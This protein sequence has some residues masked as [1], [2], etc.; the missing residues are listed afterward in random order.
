MHTEF[1]CVW[2]RGKSVGKRHL[3][4]PKRILQNNIKLDLKEEDM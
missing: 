1:L 2:G 3:G 4:G